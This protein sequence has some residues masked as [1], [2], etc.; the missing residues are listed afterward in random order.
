MYYLD[1][2]SNIGQDPP[3]SFAI[4]SLIRM[5]FSL[6]MNDILILGIDRVSLVGFS[7]SKGLFKKIFQT[8]NLLCENLLLREI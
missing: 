5:P 1:T 2:P 3:L 6:F 4:T 8:Q 7:H